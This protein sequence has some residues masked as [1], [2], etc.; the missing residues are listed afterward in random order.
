M[1]AESVRSWFDEPRNRQLIERLRR[2]VCGWRSLPNERTARRPEGPLTG[3][4]YVL[5]GTLQSM[6]RDA[7]RPPRSK[8]L[9]GKVAGSVSKK[10][11][12]VIVG[13]GRREQGGEGARAGRAD[14]R[15][16]CVPASS[17]TYDRSVRL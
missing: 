5:T 3:K 6:T 9:G 4:T 10:T 14:A 12:A 8:R 13:R 1:L 2:P 15:R 7:G 17:G 11:T 16:S